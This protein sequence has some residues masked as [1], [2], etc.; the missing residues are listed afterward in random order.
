MALTST[1]IWFKSPLLGAGRDSTGRAVRNK[2]LVSGQLRFTYTTTGEPMTPDKFGL[3][4]VD[5]VFFNPV[6]YNA[7][8]PV[9]A[10]ILIAEYNR[11][12]ETIQC[13]TT[14]TT[15]AGSGHACIVNF[16]AIGDSGA[17]PELT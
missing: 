8:V 1:K 3:E 14:G 16:L 6:S 13:V 5:Q 15:E 4:T 2:T 10:T 17:A 9:A 7:V 12:T 11:S